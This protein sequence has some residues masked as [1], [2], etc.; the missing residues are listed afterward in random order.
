ML[1]HYFLIGYSRYAAILI[2]NPSL[3]RFFGS[4]PVYHGVR[5]IRVGK[6]RI[7]ELKFLNIRQGTNLPSKPFR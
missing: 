7:Q 4:D 3:A 6:D 5:F 1:F 2:S